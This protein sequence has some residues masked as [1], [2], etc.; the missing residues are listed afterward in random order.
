M[1]SIFYSLIGIDPNF[2]MCSICKNNHLLKAGFLY[3]FSR[4]YTYSGPTCQKYLEITSLNLHNNPLGKVL[5]L[6][7]T[8]EKN[9]NPEK[10]S[11]LFQVPF[12]IRGLTFHTVLPDSEAHRLHHIYYSA[13]TVAGFRECKHSFPPCCLDQFRHVYSSVKQR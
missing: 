13:S 3:L 1:P 12:L 4:R 9:R 10:V 7:L 8:D 11:K 2:G 6:H 5:H